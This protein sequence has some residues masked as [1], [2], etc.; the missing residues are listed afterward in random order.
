MNGRAI[1]QVSQMTTAISLVGSYNA[2][3]CGLKVFGVQ[4]K[5]MQ[6]NPGDMEIT[7]DNVI[8]ISIY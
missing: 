1:M 3:S 2:I 7:P 6:P 5:T 4:G 8:W